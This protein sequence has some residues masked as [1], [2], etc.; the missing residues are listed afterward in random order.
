MAQ[1]HA[2]ADTQVRWITW[3][4]LALVLVAGI[5][6]GR[7]LAPNGPQ[8]VSAADPGIDATATRTAEL[9]E[10][11]DL[12]TKVAQPVVCTPAPDPTVTPTPTIAPPV[13]AGQEMTYGDDWTIVVVNMQ[14]VR[15]PD[16]VDATGQLVLIQLQLKNETDGKEIPPFTELRLVGP[17]GAVGRVHL[18]AS[19]EIVG[20]LWINAIPAGASEER[21]VVFDMPGAGGGAYVLESDADPT[22]RVELELEQRG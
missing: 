19:S 9:A 13:P 15:A 12:R 4:V 18:D 3:W 16:G 17:D 22:F 8:L 10:L 7:A 5:F 11:D 14:P 21:G 2:H 1:E 6:I 20:P